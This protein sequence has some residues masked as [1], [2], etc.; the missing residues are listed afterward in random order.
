[1][2]L[3][4]VD[5]ALEWAYNEVLLDILSNQTHSYA[6]NVIHCLPWHVIPRPQCW[7]TPPV[8]V[9]ENE[10]PSPMTSLQAKQR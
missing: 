8:P 7:A 5:I 6:F 10:P 3:S 1:M 4:S 9:S 2:K